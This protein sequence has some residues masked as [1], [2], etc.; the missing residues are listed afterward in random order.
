MYLEI[1]KQL[2]LA[3]IRGTY[4]SAEKFPSINEIKEIYSCGNSTAQKVLTVMHKEGTITKQKGIGYFVK[5][6]VQ[7]ALLEKYM[8]EWKLQLI[9]DINEAKMLNISRKN[10]VEII[11]EQLISIYSP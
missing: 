7:K 10:L 1:K 8:E 4:K 5:P 11:E 2:E 9:Q 3:I 6:F